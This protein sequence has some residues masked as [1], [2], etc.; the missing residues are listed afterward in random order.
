MLDGMPSNPELRT[1]SRYRALAV[2]VLAFFLTLWV[3]LGAQ[4]VR[5]P[6]PGVPRKSDGTVDMSAKAPRLPNDKPDFSGIWT[7]DEV[8]ARNPGVPPNPYD[9][10]TSRRM[11][12]LGA[13]IKGG[14]PYQPWLATQIKDRKAAGPIDD[15]HI[16]CMPDNFL[17]SWGAPHLIKLV[18][19]PTILV[20]LNEWNASY[21]QILTDGR[22]LPDESFP[23]WQGYSVGTWD[24]DTLVVETNGLRDNLWL[25][26]NGSVVMEGAKIREEYSRPD[27]G[28][29]EIKV[30]VDDP[31]AY[32][33]P[34]TVTI[35]ERVLGDAEL[36]DEICLENEKS[37]EHMVNKK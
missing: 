13:E 29:L 19:T 33:K 5:V 8:D 37:L 17:R 14:L 21:R 7:S 36:I 27:F 22:P 26:W 11:I 9:A 12:N 18:H 10:T 34:W 24:G 31:R 6:V 30:T 3:P 28:H 20:S 2:T 16:R 1:L 23:A 25:D 32:T 15:P 35:K 4:W